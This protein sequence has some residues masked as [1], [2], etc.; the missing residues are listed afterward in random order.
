VRFSDKTRINTLLITA[1]NN[2]DFRMSSILTS[3]NSVELLSMNT[4]LISDPIGGLSRNGP[5]NVRV[6]L[7]V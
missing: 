5:V 3:L 6:M 1:N 2:A 4:V 7:I